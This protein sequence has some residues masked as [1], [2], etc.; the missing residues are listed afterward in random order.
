MTARDA[1][2][3][4]IRLRH[5]QCFVAVAQHGNLRRAALSLAITQPAVTKTLNELE[6]IV[7]KP[8]FVRGRGGTTP[9]PE[10]EAFMP[11]VRASLHALGLAVDS[12][13]RE[14]E[15]APLRIGVLPTVAPAFLPQVL[16]ALLAQRPGLDLRIGTG[17]NAQLIEQL[18]AGEVDAV[19]G[20]LAD[21]ELMRGLSFEHLYAEPVVIVV[22]PKHPLLRAKARRGARLDVARYP[23]VLPPSGTQ[24][25]QVADGFLAR[26]GIDPA[27][28]RIETLD[29][30]LARAMVLQGDHLWFTP[31]GA[32]QPDL[33][34][35]A[36]VRLPPRLTPEEAVGLM[37]RTEPI[38]EGAMTA[39]LAVL[40]ARAP[41]R[42][43]PRKRP[44]RRAGDHQR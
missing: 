37:L 11:H 28:G 16:G 3:G 36:L 44:A 31:L 2:L 20:R 19:I 30:A 27:A 24:I 7:G 21:P 18:R 33:A 8:L 29:I 32:V 10:A 4:R 38:A 17:R 43:A 9:T 41:A 22:R 6:D 26:H 13:R 15:A 14:P 5:L 23:C 40:R 35:G 1:A 25:R 42:A 12:V 39:F 34:S